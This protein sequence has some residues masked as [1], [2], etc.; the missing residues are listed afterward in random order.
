MKTLKLLFFP[1]LWLLS[2]I[3]GGV[4]LLRNKAFDIGL[5]RE[6]RY[7]LPIISAGN[8]TVGGTGKT[9]LT[10]YLIRLLK[11]SCRVALLSR[12][13]KRK[14][15]GVIIAG[16][17]STAGDIGDEPRQIQSKF[18]GITVAV[19]EKRTE[20]IDKLLKI[21]N[22]EVIILD[23][24]YQ[25][26]HV[27][28]GLSIL[29]IDHSRPLWKDFTFPAGTLRE[30]KSGKKRA[31]IIV[32]TK[33]PPELSEQD[34]DDILRNINPKKN[35][36]VFFTTVA[37]SKPMNYSGNKGGPDK[38]TK[39]LAVAGIA[40]PEPFF[41]HISK[42]YRLVEKLSF[43]DHHSFSSGDCLRIG[44]IFN[45]IEPENKA[46][47]FT[48]KDFVRIKDSGC[49]KKKLRDYIWY[50][51]IKISFLFDEEKKFNLLIKN[52]VEKDKK[53]RSVPE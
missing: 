13:Y 14:T 11:D 29:L 44:E 12:G 3:Y 45:R 49:I 52:Y 1:V 24:A 33:C 37:Y 28:P 8:I 40:K 31:D 5:L 42:R 20:G 16:K 53:N 39:I 15:K 48:E 9:P 26:R 47:M 51:P 23:D 4:I 27:K 25:H 43:G 34:R 17:D 50:I 38:E 22:P 35:Q 21:K 6:R 7:D 19:A 46:V 10:E 30:P 2:L 18:P 36:Q 41:R 32:V